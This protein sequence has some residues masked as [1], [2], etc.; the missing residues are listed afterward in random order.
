MK[1]Y[2]S[3]ICI[4]L[5]IISFFGGRGA[6]LHNSHL[7]FINEMLVAVYTFVEFWRQGHFVF[8]VKTELC[9]VEVT[10][11]I[12]KKHYFDSRMIS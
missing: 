5:H 4:G 8:Y 2:I 12:V 10:L 6:V 11:K 3:Y 7:Y 9:T 1:S